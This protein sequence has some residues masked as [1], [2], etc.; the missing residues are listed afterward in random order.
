MEKFLIVLKQY[1]CIKRK[2]DQLQPELS[3]KRTVGS[4]P[5]IRFLKSGFFCKE[6]RGVLLK[7]NKWKENWLFI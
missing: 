4:F 1:F 3:Q 5:K 7:N 6:R 2:K